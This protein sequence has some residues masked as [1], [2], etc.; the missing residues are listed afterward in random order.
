MTDKADIAQLKVELNKILKDKKEIE[1]KVNHI[2][3]FQKEN[4]EIRARFAN[5]EKA[6][7]GLLFH[8]LKPKSKEQMDKHFQIL[9]YD[10]ENFLEERRIDDENE[11]NSQ[12]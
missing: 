11:T 4:L 1:E 3:N 10:Y 7:F 6:F 8:K 2:K 5:M 9:K 12:E